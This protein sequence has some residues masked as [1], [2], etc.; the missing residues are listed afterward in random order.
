MEPLPSRLE[1]VD[2]LLELGH[3]L[4]RLGPPED[5]I[6]VACQRNPWFTPYYIKRSLSGVLSW[7]EE[8]K[9]RQ[10]A[11]A[12]PAT[13]HPGKT[14]GVIAAGNI[15]L[16]GLHDLT[17][18]ALSGHRV[19]FKPSHRDRILVHW[20]V[21]QWVK[22]LPKPRNFLHLTS[23][24]SDLDYL[25]A[26]GSDNSARYFRA[27]FPSTPKLIRKHRYSV[28]ILGSKVSD[29]D[30][31]GLAAD[32]L[33]YNG[34]GCRNVSN[35]IL[36]PGFDLSRLAES[37][38]AYPSDQ[39]NP[40]Y[41]ERVLYAKHLK[42]VL[43]ETIQTLP[44]T[45]IQ[46]SDDPGSSEMGVTRLIRPKNVKQVESWLEQYKNQWQ[47]VVGRNVKFG[48]TQNPKFDDFAD[49]VDTMAILTQI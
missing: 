47:C 12:Y 11:D 15:P 26:T 5:L 49:E 6:E 17:I 33:L 48:Q 24:L 34:L 1:I 20:W 2:S 18:S 42:G 9:L 46:T 25:I 22:T 14:V 45:L 39:I 41:L 28:A 43:G 32:M 38:H 4:G 30:L 19:R 44:H 3:R 16:V 27:H 37:L 31:N 36:L 7:L 35:L 29:S 40:L 10:F 8:K 23:T 13:L 21:E